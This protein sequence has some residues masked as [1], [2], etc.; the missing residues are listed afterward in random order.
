MM[1]SYRDQKVITIGI[2]CELTGLSERQVRYYEERRLI[3]PGRSKGG[4]RIYS[5]ADIEALMDIA[6]H[7]EDGMQT[8]EIRRMNEKLKKTATAVNGSANR[9]IASK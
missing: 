4:T 2:V 1:M 5:F 8:Y 7:L 6:N 3:F 9:L